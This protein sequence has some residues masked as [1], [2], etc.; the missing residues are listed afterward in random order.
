MEWT[1]G[2]TRC[3][4]ANP[5]NMRYIRYHDE[6]WGV[7]V[8]DDQKLFEML[9]LECFQAGLTWE[10]VLNKQEAF[11]E[12][13]DNFDP[14]KICA[15]DE[16]KLESLRQNPGIIRNRLKIRAA[17]VNAGV[18]R[19]IQ[20]EYKSFSNYLKHWSGGKVIYETGL[21][22]SPLSDRISGDLKKRGMKFVGTTI[23]YAYLQAVG[24]IY[25][26]EKECFLCRAEKEPEN[27][28]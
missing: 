7:P 5:K 28:G 14:E 24:V 15:Y 4:W 9:I 27:N 6:I 13:F 23:I 18:F 17:V 22:S 8:Y 25:S 2:K 1:D 26:H 21:A 3:F 19:E 20:K 12:A 16:E 11:R 10:C